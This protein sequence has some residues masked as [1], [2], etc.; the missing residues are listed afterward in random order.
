M[1]LEE[2]PAVVAAKVAGLGSGGWRPRQR[3]VARANDGGTEC[4]GGGGKR[5]DRARGKGTIRLPFILLIIYGTS[6]V[7][8]Y[9]IP[10]EAQQAFAKFHQRKR[11]AQ[12]SGL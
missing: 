10:V 6:F 1:Y 3:A 11:C 8:I 4:R 9:V 2:G 5:R 12:V 7:D